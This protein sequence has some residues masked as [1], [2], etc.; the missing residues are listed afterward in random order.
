MQVGSGRIAMSE[1]CILVLAVL[2]KW[3]DTFKVLMTLHHEGGRI[4]YWKFQILSLD[5]RSVLCQVYDTTSMSRRRTVAGLELVITRRRDG[6]AVHMCA[7][8]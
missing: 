4:L 5:S 3:A 7:I 1:Q 8:S 2:I 6:F